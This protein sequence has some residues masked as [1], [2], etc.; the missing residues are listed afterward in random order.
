M[1]RLTALVSTRVSNWLDWAAKIK[2]TNQERGLR[3]T[4][5]WKSY[6]NQQKGNNDKQMYIEM[7]V[8]SINP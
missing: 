2:D 1:R 4:Q 6:N 5:C 8:E 7:R 3:H